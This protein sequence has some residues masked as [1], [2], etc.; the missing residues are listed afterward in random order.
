[1]PDKP[2]KGG[3][4]DPA[5]FSRPSTNVAATRTGF[6]PFAE[7][8]KYDENLSSA[9]YEGSLFNPRV[10]QEYYRGSNQGQLRKYWNGLWSAGF[11]IGTKV[12]QGLGHVGGAL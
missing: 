2:W 6:S 5:R 10:E 7:V 11:S 9:L 4:L 3:P 1:M 8:G 12:G